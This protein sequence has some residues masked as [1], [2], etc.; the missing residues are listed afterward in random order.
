MEPEVLL[1][2]LK[3]RITGVCPEPDES[4]SY[5]RTLE[6]ALEYRRVLTASTSSTVCTFSRY[7][8]YIIINYDGVV[9]RIFD[10]GTR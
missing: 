5:P 8:Q 10:L 1:R 6:T 9:S 7:I 2:P 3:K 4:I